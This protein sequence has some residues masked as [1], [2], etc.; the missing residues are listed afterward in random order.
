M[1]FINKLKQNI[2]PAQKAKNIAAKF[3]D[4]EGL[5]SVDKKSLFN[6]EKF[7]VDE[8]LDLSVRIRNID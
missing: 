3:D 5:L 1:S 4:T 6:L 2:F 8:L 7:S